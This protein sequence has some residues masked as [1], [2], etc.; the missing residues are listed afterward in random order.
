[1]LKIKKML[2]YIIFDKLY[3]DFYPL[4][5]TADKEKIINAINK[6]NSHEYL[7]MVEKIHRYALSDIK[8]K[9]LKLQELER[10]DK[11]CMKTKKIKNKDEN[12][13]KYKEKVQ[14]LKKEYKTLN[15]ENQKEQKDI[16]NYK[17]KIDILI[18]HLDAGNITEDDLPTID[19]VILNHKMNTVFEYVVVSIVL[20]AFITLI[21]LKYIG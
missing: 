14:I 9:D 7:Y 19:S 10:F 18:A 21:I 12:G 8:N 4:S 1:M 5:D 2:K 15:E 3:C 17:E 6:R 16:K 11:H 20:V 13:N